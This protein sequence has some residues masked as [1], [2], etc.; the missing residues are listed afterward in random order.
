MTKEARQKQAEEVRAANE[1]AQEALKE[2]KEACDDIKHKDGDHYM[3][4]LDERPQ[5]GQQTR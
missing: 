1:R 3:R 5:E 4:Q 2:K